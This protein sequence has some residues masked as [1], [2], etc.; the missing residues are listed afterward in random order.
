[1]R[2]QSSLSRMLA[3][4]AGI[5]FK[6][7]L[8][9]AAI[10]HLSFTVALAVMGRYGVLPDNLDRNGIGISFAADSKDYLIYCKWL[11]DEFKIGGVSA[12]LGAELGLHVKLYSLSY[13]VAGP[14]LGYNILGA[15]PLNLFYYLLILTLVFA[16]GRELF[17]RETGMLAA[18]AAALWPSLL[19]H[20]TQLLRD[21]L[22]LILFL[23]II[24]ISA[25]W[26]RRRYDWRKGVLTGILGGAASTLLWLV[27]SQMWEVM[28]CAALIAAAFL[29]LRQFRERRLLAGN[30]ISALLLCAFMAAAP[31]AGRAFN[32][33]S[34]PAEQAGTASGPQVKTLQPILPPG[35]PLP[36]RVGFLRHKF[37][38]LY[39]GA[40]SNIDTGV[41]FKSLSDILLYLPRAVMVG[42]FA[43][44]PNMWFKSGTQVGLAGRL[45]SGFETLIIYLIQSLAAF[46]IWRRRR[47]LEPW[48]LLLIILMGAVALG[49]VV[50]NIAALYRMRFGFWLL[51]AV[52]G[53]EGLR[54][55][56]RPP[57]D[58]KNQR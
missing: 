11:V 46:A 56:L 15:E 21:P 27:R 35:S 45:L 39:Q 29:L 4:A 32:I 18:C 57:P 9:A 50:A 13:A 25:G 58:L 54:Q 31:A 51:T 3:F 8:I 42:L 52:L 40:G 26:L 55:L 7:F 36:A 38:S 22:F 43:P 10:L 1:M 6:R 41:E 20:T 47:S 19:L 48:M 33:Y 2:R 49:L 17:T 28:L 23:T 12:W 53:A 37:R 24:L 16:L 30:S 5:S 14:L 34:Y 44:F